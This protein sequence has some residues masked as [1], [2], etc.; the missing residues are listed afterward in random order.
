MGRM[1]GYGSARVA[2]AAAE[3]GVHTSY[4][5]TATMNSKAAAEALWKYHGLPVSWF[6]RLRLSEAPDPAVNSS[7]K[8][9]TAAQVSQDIMLSFVTHV[10]FIGRKTSVGLSALAAAY[11]HAL[12]T[13]VE[14]TVSVNARHAVLE[15]S[16]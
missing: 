10:G 3:Q 13:G 9:G 16:G 15:F 5:R 11:F 7:F 2:Y 12:N 14:Q 6:P 4:D 8:L 1:S